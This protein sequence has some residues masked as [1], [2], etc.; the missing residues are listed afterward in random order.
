MLRK[1]KPRRPLLAVVSSLAKV[2]KIQVVGEEQA[3]WIRGKDVRATELPLE[4]RVVVWN[5][6]KGS[7][8]KQ[9]RHDFQAM[10]ADSH[11]LLCQEVLFSINRF[12]DICYPLYESVHACSYLRSDG[13]RDGVMTAGRAKVS[14]LPVRVLS[15]GREPLFNTPKAS[16]ITKYKIEGTEKHLVVVNVHSPLLRTPKQAEIEMN[17]LASHIRNYEGPLLVAGDFNTFSKGYLNVVDRTLEPLGLSRIHLV[18]DHRGVLDSLDQ[19]YTRGV[20]IIRAVVDPY[21]FSS[22]HFPLRLKLRL[23]V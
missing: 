2:V 19:A 5:T 4:T 9:F 22:D 3:V 16:L 13:F 23:N 15:K 17:H 21:I 8:G 11:L 7:G 20:E 1:P 18:D 12:N 10:C 14:D 6:F